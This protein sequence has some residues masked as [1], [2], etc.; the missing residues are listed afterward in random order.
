[1]RIAFRD[2][3]AR[4]PERP[5]LTLQPLRITLRAAHMRNV[6]ALIIPKLVWN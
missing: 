3:R 6:R 2:D 1:M 5:Y 4:L